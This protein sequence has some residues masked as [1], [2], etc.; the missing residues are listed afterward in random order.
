M[1]SSRRTEAE[2]C[3]M[4][5]RRP[6]PQN[7]VGEGSFGAAIL[8]QHDT[9]KERDTKAGYPV[10]NC[11]FGRFLHKSRPRIRPAPRTVPILLRGLLSLGVSTFVL[12]FG[13]SAHARALNVDAI[14]KA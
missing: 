9:D 7:E 4:L 12:P 3:F 2:N 1:P 10:G 6:R 5:R 13:Q 8:C 14:A 11:V